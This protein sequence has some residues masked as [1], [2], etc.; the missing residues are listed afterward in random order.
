MAFQAHWLEF[1]VEMVFAMALMILVGIHPVRT[2]RW[3]AS[4]LQPC[5]V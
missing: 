5:G 3:P 2:T 1:T 4:N